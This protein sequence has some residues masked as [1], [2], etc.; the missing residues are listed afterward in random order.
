MAN[1]EQSIQDQISGMYGWAIEVKKEFEQGHFEKAEELLKNINRQGRRLEW[2]SG[3]RGLRHLP[4]MEEVEVLKKRITEARAATE[5]VRSTLRHREKIQT[6]IQAELRKGVTVQKNI[7]REINSKLVSNDGI[8][9]KYTGVLIQILK[10]A[11]KIADSEPWYDPV[12]LSKPSNFDIATD[13][14]TKKGYYSE[15]T[16]D[17]ATI[18]VP[19]IKAGFLKALGDR[20]IKQLSFEGMKL[21]FFDFRSGFFKG[22][23]FSDSEINGANFDGR[24]LIRAMLMNVKSVK[25]IFK[26]SDLTEGVLSNGKFMDG[27]FEGA[28]LIDATLIGSNFQRANFT[29][30]HLSRANCSDANFTEANFERADLAGTC[31]KRA[32]LSGAR[33]DKAINSD[34][35]NFKGAKFK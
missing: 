33:L 1:D 23:D 26:D 27:N 16:L 28:I 17:R 21:N 34:K 29:N 10:E 22:A 24:N 8:I 14:F 32:T 7:S 18:M 31:F 19:M 4:D 2:R 11:K 20:K 9:I 12:V 25:A 5:Q 3:A 35:A 30:A 6:N 15:R 13:L